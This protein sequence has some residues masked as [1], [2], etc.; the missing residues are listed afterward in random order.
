MR[1]IELETCMWGELEYYRNAGTGSRSQ[2]SED[3]MEMT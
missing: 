1:D 2:F 3:K